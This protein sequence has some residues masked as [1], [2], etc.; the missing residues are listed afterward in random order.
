MCLISLS[1]YTQAHLDPTHPL[2]APATYTL[3]PHPHTPPHRTGHLHTLTT[4][5]HTPTALATCTL[6]PHPHTPPH[7]T[8][9]LHTLT[10]PTH[11]PSPHWPLTHSHHTHTH[12]LTAPATCTLS[13]H[14]HTP[15]HCTG[16]LHTLTTPTHTPSPH[17]PLA[18]SPHPHTPPHRTG[19]LHTLTTPTHTL[20][21]SK[22]P[23]E[24]SSVY[25][26]PRS[27]RS[28]S[29]IQFLQEY[30]VEQSNSLLSCESSLERLHSSLQR[31]AEQRTRDERVAPEGT[32]DGHVT[33]PATED[34]SHATDHMTDHVTNHVTNHVT[35]DSPSECGTP[36]CSART[37][38]GRKTS[39][40]V[41][42]IELEMDG[43]ET[44]EGVDFEV[45]ISSIK[46]DVEGSD[47]ISMSL[48]PKA[49]PRPGIL[50]VPPVRPTVDVHVQSPP[51][52]VSSISTASPL[53]S[54]A[55]TSVCSHPSSPL[56]LSPSPTPPCHEN[57]NMSQ[58]GS[59]GVTDSGGEKLTQELQARLQDSRSGQGPDLP[60]STGKDGIEHTCENS[61]VNLNQDEWPDFDL[62]CAQPVQANPANLPGTASTTIVPHSESSPNIVQ[63]FPTTSHIQHPPPH[64]PPHP[65]AIYTHPPLGGDPGPMFQMQ[66]GYEGF[67]PIGYYWNGHPGFIPHH[68]QCEYTMYYWRLCTRVGK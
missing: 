3:S 30:S 26:T 51:P 23:S 40:Y 14:P 7:R 19:H 36:T 21:C 55:S 64:P 41:G 57:G 43:N 13:P 12:T 34:P 68:V 44:D 1:L 15:P 4:P 47:G 18:H 20:T 6:S 67:Y 59:N 49:A 2:T 8:C 38:Q 10:T 62:D 54:S 32:C 11:T 61:G 63:W 33:S 56:T 25:T 16:H 42:D 37:S 17:L 5:T 46:S 60:D 50:H 39:V 52:S 45:S 65:Q 53:S 35:P 48:S 27:T 58:E 31:V 29:P 24:L 22:F 28:Q 66:S 9:H